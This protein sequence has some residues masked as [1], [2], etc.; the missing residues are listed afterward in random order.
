[1]YEKAV[2][3]RIVG[4]RAVLLVG[5]KE[6]ERPVAVAD[7]PPGSVEGV[8]LQLRFDGDTLVEAVIDQE[9]TERVRARIAEKMDR[10]RRR[11]RRGPRG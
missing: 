2:I 3:D 1:M 8:W 9:E 11:G 4:G 6:T 5:E 10:L 7:L